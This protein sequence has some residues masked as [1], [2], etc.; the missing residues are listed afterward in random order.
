MATAVAADGDGVEPEPAVVDGV[1]VGGGGEED[2][3]VFSVKP[4]VV[5]VREGGGAMA[6]PPEVAEE[7]QAQL[8]IVVSD[9]VPKIKLRKDSD[10]EDDQE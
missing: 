7:K 3:P 4:L 1:A 9:A 2:A 10:H 5:S 8:V 6:A